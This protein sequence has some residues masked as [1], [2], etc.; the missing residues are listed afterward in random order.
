MSAIRSRFG[1]IM[2]IF[3][4]KICLFQCEID[5]S[6]KKKL[7][8]FDGHLQLLILDSWRNILYVYGFS[9]PCFCFLF[10]N[11]IRIRADI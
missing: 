11:V 6:S 9:F 8:E 2:Y 1:V 4:L 5:Q 3:F 7:F 10:K